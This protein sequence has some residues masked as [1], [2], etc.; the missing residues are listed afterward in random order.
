[1]QAVKKVVHDAVSVEATRLRKFLE[2]GCDYRGPNGVYIRNKDFRPIQFQERYW[3]RSFL[4]WPKILNAQPNGSHYA[5]TELQRAGTV[6]SIL[7]QNVDRLHT[8]S[9]S[10]GVVE[11]HGSLHE[12]EC[13]GCG[14]VIPRQ[15]FQDALCK[16]NPEV[17]SWS[18]THPD[19]KTGDVASSENVN[20][21][22]DIDISWS[23]DEFAYP[24]CSKCSGIMKPSRVFWGE[25]ARSYSNDCI[26]ARE[27]CERA[28]GRWLITWGPDG[29]AVDQPC[30]R[31]Q[32][33]HRHRQF[34]AD[35]SRWAV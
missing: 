26:G 5:L 27:Q 10:H 20:P 1:M 21:D 23:Y 15:S 31:S 9:G 6:S 29:H 14:D 16:L 30:A 28:T 35:A 32:D 3:A 13:Q 33:P 18:A 8:K 4:G 11:M 17:A 7:T 34:G 24:A 22:G 12:V 25:H 2:A 19:K